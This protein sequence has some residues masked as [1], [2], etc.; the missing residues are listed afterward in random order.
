MKT[1]ILDSVTPG[2]CYYC[3]EDDR[4]FLYNGEAVCECQQCELCELVQVHDRYCDN[5]QDYQEA[6][7]R[8]KERVEQSAAFLDEKDPNNWYKAVDI[9]NL[10]MSDG[11]RCVLGQMGFQEKWGNFGGYSGLLE[12]FHVDDEKYA[13]YAAD[14]YLNQNT[15]YSLLDEY[16]THEVNRRI[17]GNNRA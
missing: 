6:K 7:E 3:G 9:K 15:E 12:F 10:D 1:I 8:V 17:Y 14:E 4:W 16:W 5:N 2:E 11:N 13:F